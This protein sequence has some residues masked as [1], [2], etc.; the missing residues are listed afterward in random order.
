MRIYDRDKHGCLRFILALVLLSST[1]LAWSND[2]NKQILSTG[3]LNEASPD[4]AVIGQTIQQPSTPTA[5]SAQNKAPSPRVVENDLSD[6]QS[7]RQ[8]PT[9]TQPV[10]DQA[11]VLSQ[12]QLKR[13]SDQIIQL[14][15]S[16]KAQIGIVIV[17][18]VGQESIFDFA[19]RIANQWKLGTAK[20]DN[21]IVI[22]V[23]VN[24]RRIQILTGYGLE[25]VLPDAIVHRIIRNQITPAFKDG[26]IA[27]GLTAGLQEIQRIL[28]LDPDVAKQAAEQLKQQQD[29]AI[30]AQESKDQM[31]LYTAV[32]LIIG[33]F[34][35]SFFGNR[36]TAS[37]AGVTAVASGMISGAGVLVSL[38][39]GA[40][41][42][43]LLITSL[44]QLMLQIFTSGGGRGGG[45]GGSG[46]GFSGGGGGFGGG[47]ASGSW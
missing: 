26:N 43:L 16:A 45:S 15:Q 44:A 4:Q 2:Q 18:T 34:S 5:S 46:G 19:M 41:V 29:R 27:Q 30:Q 33:I 22:A 23:A 38:L 12:A 32:I 20:Q 1:V 14:H 36:L 11:Q 47:G 7:I 21:G 42:F 9:L 25:G 37:V 3:V 17:P 6:G 10:I 40:G 39:L 35:S 24:D 31:L 8:L 13:L 28:N